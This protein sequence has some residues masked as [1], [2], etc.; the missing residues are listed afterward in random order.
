MNEPAFTIGI[1]E[2]YLLVERASR[3]LA[4]DPPPE[5]LSECQALLEGQ[6]SPEFLRAQ[7][8]VGT[9]VCNSVAD[10]RAELARLRRT[11]AGVAARHGLAPIAA[12]THPSAL[13]HRQKT[14]DRER[15]TLLARD[16]QAP[17]RRLVICGMHVHV[18][19]EDPEL[20]I[21]LMGQVA[22]FLPHL[23]ALSTSSPFW[24]G[25]DTG[26]NSYRIAVFAEL[27]RT[28]LPELFDSWGEYER[29]L[30][31]LVAAGLIEDGSKLWWDLRPGVGKPTL[32]MRICDVCTRLDDGIAIAAI[33]RCLTRMLWRLK[34]ANQ[35]W[36]RY[37]AML[38]NEN[39]WRAQRYGIDAG[40]VDFG[41]GAMAPYAELLDEILA[42]TR[43]D[44]EHFGCVAE[45]EHARSI[46]ARGTS[47][48]RQRAIAAA[49][50]A[51]GKTPIEA[52]RE[53]VDWLIAA[54]VEAC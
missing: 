14:T 12:A 1:E 21:D 22:Y 20:R 54:T 4:S 27:P 35:R 33:Y 23:L 49:A 10:A 31:V 39:R 26:L 29:H 15:Y 44:A 32:E 9:T 6:V 28:G 19:I 42:L 37:A 52:Q 50:R 53:I 25:E 34:R 8:E 51:A 2:E 40:L 48:H 16:I 17:A 43:E 24:R 7:I 38:I 30:G 13:W 36:R 5:M 11:V 3:E 47:A 46:L 18:G 41:K 45:V